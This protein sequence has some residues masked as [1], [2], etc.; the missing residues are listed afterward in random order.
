MRSL[1]KKL[2]TRARPTRHRQV[3]EEIDLLES[4]PPSPTTDVDRLAAQVLDRLQKQGHTG[5]IDQQQVPA[6]LTDPQASQPPPPARLKKESTSD[7]LKRLAV[8][9]APPRTRTVKKG[10]DGRKSLESLIGSISM[11]RRGKYAD[12][13][14][15]REITSRWGQGSLVR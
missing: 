5:D 11:S 13:R 1:L 14:C 2:M 15:Y 9:T 12:L 4:P 6:F 8:G 7:R 10:D 3:Q